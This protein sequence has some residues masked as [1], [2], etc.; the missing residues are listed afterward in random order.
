[1]AEEAE[2]LERTIHQLACHE[3]IAD[4]E[5]AIDHAIL[6]GDAIV[7]EPLGVLYNITVDESTDWLAYL[8]SNLHANF[9]NTY[10]WIDE[11]REPTR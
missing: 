10:P 9:G 8:N 3:L 5:S 7:Q 2:I 4:C 11:F 1:M 6:Y